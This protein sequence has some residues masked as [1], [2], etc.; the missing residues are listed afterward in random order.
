MD[1]KDQSLQSDL[2]MS[3]IAGPAAAALPVESPPPKTQ[4]PK[5]RATPKIEGRIDL[6][7]TVIAYLG[8]L[9]IAG[10]LWYVGARF[11]LVFL[12]TLAP[13]LATV[14]IIAWAIPVIIT[15]IELTLWPHSRTSSILWAVFLVVLTFDIGT[16][17]AGFTQWAG[18]RTVPLFTGIMVPSGG[19]QLW[20]L[21]IGCGLLFAFG[22]ERLTRVAIG[23]LKAIVARW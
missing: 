18:G 6:V 1:T 12:N 13:G 9:G 20:A 5:R 3:G 7:M 16:S 22:P 8:V 14:G 11:T 17:F 4:R 23:E 21:G 2:I 19:W 10:G 15:A